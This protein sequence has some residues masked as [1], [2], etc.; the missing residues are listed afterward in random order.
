MKKFFLAHGESE[1]PMRHLR[2]NTEC[3]KCIP[4]P[5]HRKN[6]GRT[7]TKVLSYYF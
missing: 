4:M 6:S 5:V 1:L 7:H 2:S 3:I